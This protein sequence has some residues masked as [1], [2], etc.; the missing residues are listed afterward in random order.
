M[1]KTQE[2]PD[3]SLTTTRATTEYTFY[4]QEQHPFSNNLSTSDVLFKHGRHETIDNEPHSAPSRIDLKRSRRITS[5]LWIYRNRQHYESAYVARSFGLN[6]ELRSY[7]C[8]QGANDLESTANLNAGAMCCAS[9]TIPCS[10]AVMI[11]LF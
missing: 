8:M 6:S 1:A 5:T 4:G 10:Q 2:Y 11:C 7:F 9:H 3:T